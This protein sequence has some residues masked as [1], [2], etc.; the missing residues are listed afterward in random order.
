VP[1]SGDGVVP[2]FRTSSP[3]DSI[4]I[5]NKN[6]SS[7]SNNSRP[8][9]QARATP[10]EIAK[11]LSASR[12][13]EDLLKQPGDVKRLKAAI[14]SE[15]FQFDDNTDGI[16]VDL[17]VLKIE[18][19]SKAI[20]MCEKF[21][22]RMLQHYLVYLLRSFK[23]DLKRI[24]VQN[25]SGAAT[26]NSSGRKLNNERG[27][28]LKN[29]FR[30]IQSRPNTSKITQHSKN[31]NTHP[32]S[33]SG[34]QNSSF[35]Q[36]LPI[37]SDT[38][39]AAIPPTAKSA[40]NNSAFNRGLHDSPAG[41]PMHKRQKLDSVG[42]TP[43]TSPT[44]QMSNPAN[45]ANPETPIITHDLSLNL[46]DKM[47]GTC[48]NSVNNTGFSSPISNSPDSTKNLPKTGSAS[49]L[50]SLNGWRNNNLIEVPRNGVDHT[51]GDSS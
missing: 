28:N 33:D 51:N 37:S 21:K 31:D 40:F 30:P 17:L 4:G 23:E 8:V 20:D 22:R 32:E 41:A 38:K 27:K 10:V 25:S 43:N 50:A 26:P 3:L 7:S 15:I 49:V 5:L 11:A 44:Y 14:K 13:I 16:N 18:L 46:S 35:M 29:M 48:K 34:I 47:N 12:K 42:N 39:I 1:S 24:T 2:V 45:P 6:L 19:T 36:N 9:S